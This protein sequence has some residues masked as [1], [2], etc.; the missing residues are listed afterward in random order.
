MI[1][2]HF[3]RI[4]VEQGLSQSSV[5]AIFQDHKGYMWFGTLN[6]LNR[7]DGYN[8]TDF[9]HNPEDSSSI[10]SDQIVA[11]FE[12]SERN[13]WIG[14]QAGLNKFDRRNQKFVRYLHDS[15]D[16]S[17]I[18]G[19]Y[20]SA[21]LEDRTGVLWVGT[22]YGL[23][24]LNKETEAFSRFV[25]DPNSPLSLSHNQISTLCE[26]V[27]G[28]LWV[29][30]LGGGLSKFDPK[31]E[32]VQH[33]V[34]Y[35][36]RRGLR[37]R[38]K[39]M[40]SILD[41]LTRKG[42]F[43]AIRQV[44]NDADVSRDFR[45]TEETEVL[46]VATG[47]TGVEKFDFG[48]LAKDGK[49]VWEM[50]LDSTRHAGGHV[51]NRIEIETLTLAAGDYQLRYKSDASHSYH[52][53]NALPPQFES[54]WGIQ[55]VAVTQR[56]ARFLNGELGKFFLPPAPLGNVISRIVAARDG[57]LW[58]GSYQTGV[59]KFSPETDSGR[60]RPAP[61][62][63]SGPVNP[64]PESATIFASAVP[65][66]RLETRRTVDV[67]PQDAE[68]LNSY[69]RYREELTTRYSPAVYDKIGQMASNG[70]RLAAILRVQDF[71][72]LSAPFVIDERTTVLIVAMG[73]AVA[74]PN[75]YGS[76][77]QGQ[78]TIW[79]L[80][81]ARSRHAG[82][83]IK[84]RIQITPLEL[85]PGE[86]RLEYNSDHN[87]S[88]ARWNRRPPDHP[89][90]WGAQ[91]L[92]VSAEDLQQLDS[93]LA[94][95]ERPSQLAGN[96]VRDLIADR[97]GDLWIATSAGISK[98]DPQ[99][100]T[101]T[102]FKHDPAD[103][104]SLSTNDVQS[105]YQ[106]RAG[107][108]WVGT[109]LGGINKFN[110]A[111]NRF[112]KFSP[113]PLDENSLTNEVVY[114]F[115]ED[116]E[117]RLWIGTRNGLTLFD[118][119]NETFFNFVGSQSVLSQIHGSVM[120]IFPDA[121]GYLW[122]ASNRGVY[123]ILPQAL[124]F[125]KHPRSAADFASAAP[126]DSAFLHFRHEPGN[127]N[128][129][130]SDNT[131]GI[132]RDSHGD[133]WIATKDAGMDRLRQVTHEAG[134]GN[135]G[136][137]FRFKHYRFNSRQAA[138][139]PSNSV[140][141]L[142]ED[143]SG[144]L[145]VGTGGGGLCRLNAK[146]RHFTRYRHLP[147]VGSS[148]SHNTVNSIYEDS[149]GAFWVATYGGGL[150]KFDPETATFQRFLE[151]D[152]LP[153]NV[154]Y[155]ILPD[156]L[157][158]LWLSTNKGLCRFSL[159]TNQVK[160]YDMSN[161]LQS[162]EF[163]T[164]AY[165]RMKNGD[166][167]FGGIN[168]FN[169]IDPHV[170]V[171]NANPPSVVIT[172]FK[173]FDEIVN[174]DQD[175]SELEEVVL[176]HEENFISFEFAALDYTDSKKNQY[177][178]KLENLHD[179]WIFC[180]NQRAVSFANLAPGNY[181]FR[182]NGTN[183]DG[184]WNES[185]AS[186]RVIIDPP[187]WKTA[188]FI[189]LS[190]VISIL[191]LLAFHGAQVNRKVRQSVAMERV[192]LHERERLRTQVSRDYHDALGHRLTKISLF[193]ELLRR[194]ING[195]QE[196]STYLDKIVAAA[197]S[198]SM[199]TRAFIWTVDPGKDCLYDLALFLNQVGETLFESTGVEFR[200]AEVEPSY[201]KI[202]LSMD[203]KRQISLIFKE[204]MHNVLKHANCH[205]A[206]LALKVL[207]GVLAIHLSDDGVGIAD[208]PRSAAGFGSGNGI[209]NMQNRSSSIGGEV[210]ITRMAGGGTLVKFA[211]PLSGEV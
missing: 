24:R 85:D 35:G 25:Y 23:N 81:P 140:R 155:G 89:D 120:S 172:A 15:M 178:Y 123:R 41:I 186:L 133:I 111:K 200:P 82:G 104:T 206:E 115:A 70:A 46:I 180:G 203:W 1:P 79:Q 92:D 171:D 191:V 90:F 48:W 106:D 39:L 160:N 118:R 173:K 168:G 184:V 127:A 109:I 152:G 93:L 185:G 128:S 132:M 116:E 43:A 99:A 3:E 86:Y 37:Y 189:A 2:S 101:F 211:A 181:V 156:D 112:R 14:T 54:L 114:A 195:S 27:A 176:S 164:G 6:G 56:E 96:S 103:M 100:E 130:A 44:G 95:Q 31:R 91:V 145:W 209:R 33:Y 108:I 16:S 199:E 134:R 32:S 22:S 51:K 98:M 142:Y 190:S 97:D 60:S 175:I 59:Y 11:I 68:L 75:D 61:P 4:S 161:G 138:S 159:R 26:D 147:G 137:A 149:D 42:A 45:L 10:S 53:W 119:E 166:L 146:T 188:W 38:P 80:D 9:R 13:L 29:G 198:L 113:N 117:G 5:M 202:L 196:A 208:K 67:E 58:V 179:N 162:N 153:N 158:H 94:L 73:E 167:I 30:T 69:A 7:Y 165:L 40:R 121:G 193:S 20:V 63:N 87:H 12:D 66:G 17:T 18:S 139:L 169:I 76:L 205:H 126:A 36:N 210:V 74:R 194:N 84:N 197:S 170:I 141:A 174:F 65:P 143:S 144:N 21:I 83:G 72:A 187:F 62:L 34:D 49:V 151:K 157:G 28:N 107:T 50:S 207:D 77:R 124:I 47:E 177:A 148:L 136:P 55:V 122:I 163:N 105:I 88:Y 64:W 71:A 19:D 154:V 110:G 201:A 192:R 150:N 125:K 8:F 129:L 182:V 131:W 183:N 102:N 78:R 57:T 52:Q 204:A 135:R